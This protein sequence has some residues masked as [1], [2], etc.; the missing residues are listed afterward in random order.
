M[1][2]HGRNMR[3]VSNSEAKQTWTMATETFDQKYTVYS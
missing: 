1:L 2:A 3:H